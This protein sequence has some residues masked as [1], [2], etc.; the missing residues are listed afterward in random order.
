MAT[1]TTLLGILAKLYYNTG[2][3]YGSPTWTAIDLVGDLQVPAK[4]DIAEAIIRAS[5]IKFKNKT[6]LDIGITG[7]LLAS[8]TN[9]AFLAVAAAMINDDVLDVMALNA[10]NSTNGAK[11]Y[12]FD[13][14]V[15]NNTE[16]QGAG[17]IIWDDFELVPA[18]TANT[19]KTVLVATGA[20][21]FT[22][23]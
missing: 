5:R 11:G 21:V 3:S 12:R 7:K 9:T 23:I 4:W 15:V 20:P 18:L 6:A 13:C 8:L 14:Q 16:D 2:G 1:P 22:A 19:P 10:S 17:N